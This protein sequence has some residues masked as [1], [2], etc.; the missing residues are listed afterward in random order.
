MKIGVEYKD[1]QYGNGPR[2][3]SHRSLDGRLYTLGARW[4]EPTVWTRLAA[5]LIW[6][7]QLLLN[8][9]AS[10]DLGLGGLHRWCIR[11]W[12]SSTQARSKS[13]CLC[14]FGSSRAVRRFGAASLI[15]P[16]MRRQSWSRESWRP[17]TGRVD[18]HSHPRE[19]NLTTGKLLWSVP[20]QVDLCDRNRDSY[21]S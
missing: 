8:R 2:C 17:A 15:Q 13:G 1:L 11:T 3:H 12:S 7:H 5:K 9:K 4:E 20:F 14:G 18:R 6:T 10:T 16:G 21:L 19:S